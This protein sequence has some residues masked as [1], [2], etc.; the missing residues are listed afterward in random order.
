MHVCE[1][2][3]ANC[4]DSAAA[5]A[6]LDRLPES[7]AELAAR[8]SLQL[9]A[10]FEGQEVSCAW[11]APAER[12]DGT[13]AVLKLSMPHFEGEQEIE[14]LRFW[15]GSP[16]VRLLEADA[17]Q[18]ALL[19]ERCEPGTHLRALPELEQDAELARLFPRL[20]RVPQASH[21]FRPLSE[22]LRYWGDEARKRSAEWLDAALV[23]EGLRL[24]EELSCPAPTDVLL[25]T[26]LHAGNVLR[27][28][29]EPW[30]VIDPKPFVGDPSYDLTQHLLNCRARLLSQ[31][32]DTLRRLGDLLAIDTERL[33][34]W[35]FARLAV[36]S[37]RRKVAAEAA[38]LARALS[39]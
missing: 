32:R 33:R 19:L 36:E 12:A 9:A 21:G 28:A 18:G 31:P 30:L 37:S 23:S 16:T 24:F 29:R 4:R 35:T 17:A 22:M 5:T 8:W 34:Q 3:A 10:P 11:V 1:R 38:A 15:A 2:L 25:A 13:R 14:G 27:A 7:I 6:W 26:D 39:G 20:W